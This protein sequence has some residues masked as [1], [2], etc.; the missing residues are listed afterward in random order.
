MTPERALGEDQHT[1]P[2]DF[3]RTA[4]PLEQL[5]RRVGIRLLDL[6]RQTGGPW[7]VVS[8]DAVTDRNVHKDGEG[9]NAVKSTP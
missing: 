4:A 6:G 2:G 5:N 7:F 9:E 8:N 3:E 1:V